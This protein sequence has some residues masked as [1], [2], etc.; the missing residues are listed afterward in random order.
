[1]FWKRNFIENGEWE[2]EGG[3]SMGLV[4]KRNYQEIVLDLTAAILK[5]SDLYLFLEMKANDWQSLTVSQK[6]ELAL[7][8]ADDIFYGLDYQHELPVGSGLVKYLAASCT[9]EVY[10]CSK[11]VGCIE[12]N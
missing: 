1:M 11:L 5:I 8:L 7:T 9:I 4:H 6:R 2:K 3:G 10:S 12:L